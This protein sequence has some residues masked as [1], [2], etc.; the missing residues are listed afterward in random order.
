M[1]NWPCSNVPLLISFCEKWRAKVRNIPEWTIIYSHNPAATPV[2][3]F[4]IV[5]H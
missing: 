3:F 2:I 5:T 4:L 1:L